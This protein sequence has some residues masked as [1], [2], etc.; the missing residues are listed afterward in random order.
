MP[1][2]LLIIAV[3]SLGL[4]LEA[5]AIITN[6]KRSRPTP[7]RARAQTGAW[8]MASISAFL[9][10]GTTLY[11]QAAGGF[12]YYDP[13]LMRIYQF[14]LLTALVGGVAGILGVGRVRLAVVALSVLMLIVWA[15]LCSAE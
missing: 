15:M 12:G 7:W 13:T 1:W 11:A 14:G 6:R 3:V 4:V 9:F 5:V 2:D 8:V 10:L